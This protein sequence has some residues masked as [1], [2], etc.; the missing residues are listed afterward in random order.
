MDSWFDRVEVPETR[1]ELHYGTRIVRCFADRPDNVHAFL[2][3]AVARRPCGTALIYG[4]E[5]VTYRE[6]DDLV[7]RAAAGL[8]ARGISRGDRVALILG[9]SIEFVVVMFAAARLGAVS[10]PLN[11][12][13]QEAENRYILIDCAAKLVV[14]DDRLADRLPGTGVV[15]TLEDTIPVRQNEGARL[16]ELLAPQPCTEVT[17]VEEEATATILYTSGTTG[18]PKGAML[19]HLSRAHSAIHYTTIMQLTGEDRCVVAVPMSHVSGVSAMIDAIMHCAGTLIIMPEFNAADFIDL[20][21]R[22][23]M[24]FTLM[25]PAMF[26]LCLLAPNFDG[27]DLS[28]W[29]VSGYG[30][31]IMPEATLERIAKK[32]PDLKLVNTYGSTETTSP[33]VFMPPDQAVPRKDFVGLTVP[34]GHIVVMNEIGV[35]V[36]PNTPGEI[37]VGGAMVVPGYWANP[38]ATA[39]EFKG[40]YWKSGDLGL[41][42]EQGYL[43]VVDRIKDVINRGGYKIFASEVENV[44]LDHPSVIE[45]AVVS[46]PCPVLGERVHAFVVLCREETTDDELWRHCARRLADYKVPETFFRVELALPRNANGKVLKRELCQRLL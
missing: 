35:E 7:G 31:A 43:R 8:A 1:C 38:E 29:R 30:G 33:A 23:R 18:R 28:S 36:P 20:A 9:N 4:K 13:H 2:S 26:N 41:I 10:V 21:V 37:Y 17:R 14:Y 25:V 12:R 44:L 32:L 27:A 3:N 5:R 42:D 46:K 19:T 40:G 16:A 45:A 24:T 39:R 6:L 11:I 22:H 15:P 34:C